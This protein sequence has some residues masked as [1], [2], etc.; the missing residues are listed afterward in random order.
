MRVKREPPHADFW[1]AQVL[2]ARTKGH[3]FPPIPLLAEIDLRMAFAPNAWERTLARPR[4]L[5][6][7]S[8]HIIAQI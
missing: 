7:G 6:H 8:R 2:A 5:N 4:Y 3:Q 1:S